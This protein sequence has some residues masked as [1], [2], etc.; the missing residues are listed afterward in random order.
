MEVQD[1]YK[2]IKDIINA[3]SINNEDR[4]DRVL[5]SANTINAEFDTKIGALKSTLLDKIS[6][7]KQELSGETAGKANELKTAFET[8]Q[9]K[10]TTT[11]P[12]SRPQHPHPPQAP[13]TFHDTSS[14]CQLDVPTASA[15]I[16]GVVP[17]ELQPC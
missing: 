6:E 3:N 1:A 7:F 17:P 12:K 2:E 15:S 14:R 10:N 8:L 16:P 13:R 9:G 5:N 11:V 4:F